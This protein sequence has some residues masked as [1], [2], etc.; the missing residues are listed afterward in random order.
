MTKL[1]KET[2]REKFRRTVKIKESGRFENR[3]PNYTYY[4]VD[5]NQ[6]KGMGAIE[7][8]MDRGYEVV[9]SKDKPTDDRAIGAAQDGKDEDLRES[10]VMR[11]TSISGHTQILMRALKS[12]VEQNELDDK[13]KRDADF[14]AHQNLKKR[15]R[16]LD[17]KGDDV[18]LT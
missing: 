8:A 4:W 16:H 9:Y 11:T 7:E 3:D 10:P 6:R 18:D 15:G 2:A 1:T 12:R 14:K 17:I 13:K 5:V